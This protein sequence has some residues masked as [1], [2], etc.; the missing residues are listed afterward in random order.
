MKRSVLWVGVAFAA[1]AA[2]VGL[3][4]TISYLM[5]FFSP[6]ALVLASCAL[7]AVLVL[8]REMHDDLYLRTGGTG[9]KPAREQQSQSRD[10]SHLP[11]RSHRTFVSRIGHGIAASVGN[12]QLLRHTRVQHLMM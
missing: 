11:G 3:A 2:G 8:G 4:V 7:L 6:E 12:M 9:H 5:D 1:I 10:I